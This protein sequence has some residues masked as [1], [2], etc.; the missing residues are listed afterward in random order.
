DSAFPYEAF[1]ACDNFDFVRKVRLFTL[2]VYQRC[3]N[4]DKMLDRFKIKNLLV[5]MVDRP[6]IFLICTRNEGA[7]YRQ[8]MWE[9]KRG[10]IYPELCLGTPNFNVYRIH[11]KPLGKAVKR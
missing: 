10:N 8:Y 4:A 5:D 11:S 2:A 7:F 9:R 1:N 6:D 3:P